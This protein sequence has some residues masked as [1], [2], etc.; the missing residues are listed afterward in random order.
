MLLIANCKPL[1]QIW[2]II[3]YLIM[4]QRESCGDN[5]FFFSPYKVGPPFL[6][7]PATVTDG[8]LEEK[9]SRSI[10]AKGGSVW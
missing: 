4:E 7:V 5:F 9:G 10:K 8:Q 2:Y 1:K 3:F 6:R